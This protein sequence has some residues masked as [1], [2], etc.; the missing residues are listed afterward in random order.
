MVKVVEQDQAVGGE[1]T[2]MSSES[3]SLGWGNSEAISHS[4]QGGEGQ[5]VMIQANTKTKA[6]WVLRQGGILLFNPDSSTRSRMK[7]DEGSRGEHPS[8]VSQCY[9]SLYISSAKV[10]VF[11]HLSEISYSSDS[12]AR[13]IQPRT[14]LLLSAS[15]RTR[16]PKLSSFTVVASPPKA[17][18]MARSMTA[19]LQGT[20]TQQSTSA[21]ARHVNQPRIP[22]LLL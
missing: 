1:M 21:P 19:S 9:R 2:G 15:K 18:R 14:D 17:R 16:S 11:R 22:C 8:P 10:L 4:L 5:H 3:R 6:I 20:Q 12:D 13:P 7:P